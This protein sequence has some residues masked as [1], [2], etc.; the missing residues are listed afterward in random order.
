M[1]E[2]GKG[3]LEVGTRVRMKG[4][5]ETGTIREVLEERGRT[6]YYVVYDRTPPEETAA[7]VGEPGDEFGVYTLAD[8]FDVLP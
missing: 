2:Q 5:G 8:T 4:T 1:A 6:L 7:G 3:D